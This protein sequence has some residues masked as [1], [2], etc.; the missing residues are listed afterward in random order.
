MTDVDVDSVGYKPVMN[1]HSIPFLDL[2][3]TIDI[4]SVV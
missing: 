3:D 1:D 2:I 4:V